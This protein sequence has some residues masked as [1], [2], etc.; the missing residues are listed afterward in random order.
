MSGGSETEIRC[1][2]IWILLSQ[3]FRQAARS[4]FHRL[5]VDSMQPNGLTLTIRIVKVFSC[6]YYKFYELQ[7]TAKF[8]TMASGRDIKNFRRQKFSLKILH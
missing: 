6:D 5:S 3:N 2:R 1:F 7:K 8:V 4:I